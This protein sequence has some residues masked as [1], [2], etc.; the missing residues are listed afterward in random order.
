MLLRE[1]MFWS[2]GPALRISAS[3][4]FNSR[5]DLQM[6]FLFADAANNA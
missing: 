5:I 6:S 4:E 1:Q 2:S 3:K